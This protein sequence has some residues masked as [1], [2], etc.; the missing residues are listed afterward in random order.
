M[1]YAMVDPEGFG[2]LFPHGEYVGRDEQAEAYY[3]ANASAQQLAELEGMDEAQY[4]YETVVN[5]R[6]ATSRKFV[7][8]EGPVEPELQPRVF[9][10]KRGGKNL[11]SMMQVNSQL[12]VVDGELR[13]IIERFEPDIHQFWPIEIRR[14]GRRGQP[15]ERTKRDFHALVI[16]QF[17]DSLIEEKSDLLDRG[18]AGRI[19]FARDTTKPGLKRIALSAEAIG[20]AHLWREKVLK[21]PNIFVSDALQA[22]IAE[23]GLRVFR[24]G[25]VRVV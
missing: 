5:T 8:D 10:I 17:R 14:P 19:R 6:Y 24:H 18:E 7:Y 1:A 23:A 25:P 4:R 9:Q 12:L 13:G 15:G 11:A 22:A 3:L 21:D 2:A 20:G 16:R